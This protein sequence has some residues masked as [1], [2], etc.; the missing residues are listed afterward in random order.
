VII[1]LKD[2]T[3]KSNPEQDQG[4]VKGTC[5]LILCAGKGI[6]LPVRFWP[7]FTLNPAMKTF[8][9]DKK[10]LISFLNNAYLIEV[11]TGLPF[12]KAIFPVYLWCGI[13]HQ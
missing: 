4:S 8:D 9:G 1:F 6:S 12:F 11:K 5:G 3:L 2:S 7:D 13:F 10:L